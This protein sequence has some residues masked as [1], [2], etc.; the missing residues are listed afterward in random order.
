VLRRRYGPARYS[1]AV[2]VAAVIAGWALAQE[3]RLLPRLSVHA[4]AAGHTT[5]VEL[6]IAVPVGA[7][8]LIP[9][10][11]LLFRLVLKG[12]FDPGAAPLTTA[13]APPAPAAPRGAASRVEAGRTTIAAA[14]ACLAAG[15]GFLTL[16]DPP[17]AHFVGIFALLGFVVLAAVALISAESVPTGPPPPPPTA[18][19][20]SS[21]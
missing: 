9:S 3:P 21:K 18:V 10:L 2:A 11:A 8:I 20:K 5:L 15:V 13:L 12:R 14:G 6:V 16:A 19:T 17:W 7:V 4:A 1:A